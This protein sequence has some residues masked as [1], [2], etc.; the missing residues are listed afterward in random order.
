MLP[1][2]FFVFLACVFLTY[3]LYLIVSRPSDVRRARLDERLAEAI[4]ASAHTNDNDVSLAREE[5]LSEIPWMN[6]LLINLQATSKIKRMIDQADSR[7]TVLKLVLFSLTAGVMSVL[8]VSMLSD[9]YL[10]M[11]VFGLIATVAPFTHM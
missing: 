10:L 4:R 11:G 3:A 5:L 7:I 2:P 8:A 9:S 6:R 1:I